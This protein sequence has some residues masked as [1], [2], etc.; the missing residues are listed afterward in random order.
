[1]AEDKK[2][3]APELKERLRAEFDKDWRKELRKAVPVKERMKPAARR[4]RSGRPTCGTGIS[5]RSTSA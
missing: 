1:M 2:E 4:C 5:R 3:L